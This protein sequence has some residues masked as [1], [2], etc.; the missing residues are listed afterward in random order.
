MKLNITK[1]EKELKVIGN[2]DTSLVAS[3]DGEIF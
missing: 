3:D 2:V 1:K